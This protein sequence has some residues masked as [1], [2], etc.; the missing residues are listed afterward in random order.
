MV[1]SEVRFAEMVRYAC[2]AFHALEVAFAEELELFC[3]AKGPT[4][5]GGIES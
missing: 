4:A 3:R 1:R 2:R 5:T